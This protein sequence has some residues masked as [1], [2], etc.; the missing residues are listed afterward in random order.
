MHKPRTILI[1]QALISLMM[2][3]FMTG[4]FSFL[5]LGF[6]GRWFEVWA[7]HFVLAWPVAFCLS[8]PVSKI[9][10][11]VAGKLYQRS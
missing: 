11:D 2:A 8:L 10:F 3:F 1:A 6:S 9:A 4:F 7:G 5:E